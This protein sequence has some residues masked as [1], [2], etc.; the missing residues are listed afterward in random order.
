MNKYAFF[1]LD[2]T[3]LNIKTMF[4]FLKFFW[5]SK[6]MYGPITGEKKFNDFVSN[7]ESLYVRTSQRE[8]VNQYYYSKFSGIPVSLVKE[9]SVNWWSEVVL[10]PNLFNSIAIA[11]LQM[12]K[13]EGFQ[14]VLVTGSM[15]A[16]VT[17]VKKV[18]CVDYS[19]HTNLE[20]L[21]GE[22][23]GKIIGDVMIGEGKAIAMRQFALS[24]HLNF[25][26][27]YAY[28]DHYSDIPMLELTAHPVVVG[29]DAKLI[30]YGM[31]H[32]WNMLGA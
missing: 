30:K 16:C 24:N 10:Q 18:L 7:A 11:E 6:E 26:D 8:L 15:H 14:I 22:Y 31:K 1:D 32:H 20:E 5:C 12:R 21:S 28:G 2:G 13:A 29:C 23:T 27:C 3:L 4:S 17:H 19:L 25:E 9:I